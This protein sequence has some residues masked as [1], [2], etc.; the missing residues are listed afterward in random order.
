MQIAIKYEIKNGIIPED[1]SLKNLGLDNR[2]KYKH[3]K[4]RYIKVKAY[5]EI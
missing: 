5:K 3:D 4:V 1:V 2:L